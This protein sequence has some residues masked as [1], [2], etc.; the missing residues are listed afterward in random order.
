MKAIKTTKTAGRAG[1]TGALVGVPVLAGMILAT[2]LRAQPPTRATAGT[3]AR[4]GRNIAAPRSSRPLTPAAPARQ[5]KQ[6]GQAT[7]PDQFVFFRAAHSRRDTR[8]EGTIVTLSGNVVIVFENTTLRTDAAVLNE[9][10]QIAT[11][12]GTVQIDDGQNTI[13][14]SRGVAYY[15]KRRADF[16]NSVRITVRPRTQDRSAPEGSLRREF[17]EPVTVSCNT[18]QYNWRQKRATAWGDLTFKQKNRTLVAEQAIYDGKKETL[19]LNGKIRGVDNGDTIQGAQALIGLKEGAEFFE[20]AG[21]KEAALSGRF[22]VD[23]ND[24]AADA[25]ESPV[26]TTLNPN[27]GAASGGGSSPAAPPAPAPAPG[28]TPLPSQPQRR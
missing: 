19:L 20:I 10:T 24:D 11:S 6:T 26:P 17:K 8:P 16:E 7:Q 22:R 3:A 5:I 21:S 9:T 28:T 15:K 18:G 14:A 27:G 4:P 13:R 12:P 2:S 23:D 1:W 25:G